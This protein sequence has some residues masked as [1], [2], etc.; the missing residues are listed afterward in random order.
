MKRRQR[1]RMEQQ[2]PM[3]KA[4]AMTLLCFRLSLMVEIVSFEIWQKFSSS[5]AG[6][7]WSD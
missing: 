3:V 7:M 1:A 5:Y 2:M 4:P 6:W